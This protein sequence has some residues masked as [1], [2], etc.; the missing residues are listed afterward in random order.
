MTFA[1]GTGAKWI[2]LVFCIFP[3]LITIHEIKKNFYLRKFFNLP[4]E[5]KKTKMKIKQPKLSDENCTLIGI[6]PNR[7]D[8]LI[9]DNAKHTFICG[10]T[11][12]GKTV[13]IAN[14]IKSIANKDYPAVIIDG[15]GDVGKG[16]IL[17]MVKVLAPFRKKYIIDLN[18]PN[19]SDSYNPFKDTSVTVVKDML[20]NMSDWSEEHY[21][22]NTERYLQRVIGVLKKADMK[23]SFKTIIK[24]MATDKFIEVSSQLLKSKQISKEEHLENVELAKISGRIAED[25]VARFA[26]IAESEL[27][28]LFLGPDGVDVFQALKE[29]A[30]IIFVLNPLIYPEISPAF[31]R[32]ALIDCKKAVSKL[33]EDDRRK[34]FIFDEVSSYASTSLL[35]LVNKSRSADVSCVLATQSLSDLD[36]VSDSFKE[37]VIENCNNYIVLRQNSAVNAE[38]WSNILGT[39]NTIDVTYQLKQDGWDTMQTGLGS[40][41]R[42]REFLYHPDYIKTLDVGK[43]IFLSKDSGYHSKVLINKPF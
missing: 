40:A 16:S 37:Q 11:G 31:G 27:Y 7:K 25:A 18:N 20:I 22:L 5:V 17:E 13:T 14:F 2:L 43:G 29:N 10:T 21:K 28:P 36:T 8:V 30:I 39:R 12:S 41:R 35:D 23:F 15:K 34:F 19:K 3:L 42:T 4:R 6:T 1:A 38:N 24:H 32:L 26:T 33:F 9:P